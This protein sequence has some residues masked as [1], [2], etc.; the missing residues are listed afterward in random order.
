LAHWLEQRPETLSLYRI[1]SNLKEVLSPNYYFFANHPNE[2]VGVREHEKFPYLLLPFFILGLFSLD[3]RKNKA[4][5][6]FFIF[7]PILLVALAGTYFDIEPISLYPVIAVSS[8]LG[9]E[10]GWK[11]IAKLIPKRFKIIIVGIS[12]FLYVLVFIQSV[13]FDRF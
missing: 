2:R 4:V 11:R 12:I 3:Y 9:I 6:A 7:A 10:H 8:V 13:F 5:I 1:Q